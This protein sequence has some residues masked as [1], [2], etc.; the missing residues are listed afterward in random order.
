MPNCGMVRL[1]ASATASA[2]GVSDR[3]SPDTNS[4]SH[5]E[6]FTRNLGHG[7]PRLTFLLSAA[8]T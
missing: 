6:S 7:K 4:A 1:I 3:G 8:W 2:V 5:R